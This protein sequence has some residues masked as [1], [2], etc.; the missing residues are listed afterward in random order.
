MDQKTSY[1]LSTR[2]EHQKIN[3]EGFSR[4][5]E[6]ATLLV[7]DGPFLEKIW[8]KELCSPT[9]TS[10]ILQGLELFTVTVS[11][12]RQQT[13]EDLKPIETFTAHTPVLPGRKTKDP[14]GLLRG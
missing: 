6:S 7:P 10:Q 9:L 13:K 5:K 3:W 2:P 1:Y 11:A 8:E 12:L 14:N 4:W